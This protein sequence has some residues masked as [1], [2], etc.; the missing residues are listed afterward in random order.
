MPCGWRTYCGP[1]GRASRHRREPRDHAPQSTT[2]SQ[3]RMNANTATLKCASSQPPC[4]IS[5]EQLPTATATLLLPR[6]R[7]KTS[8]RLAHFHPVITPLA[9]GRLTN[10]S[11]HILRIDDEKQWRQCYDG[12]DLQRRR[13]KTKTKMF[14]RCTRQKQ[15]AFDGP[16]RRTSDSASKVASVPSDSPAPRTSD[17][18]PPG[19][20][21]VRR[22]R[23]RAIASEATSPSS[24]ALWS[25]PGGA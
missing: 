5:P 25:A 22:R 13:F 4:F 17:G 21:T 6:R 18:R 24:I 15:R 2:S 16:Q 1:V 12:G 7:G 10:V 14:S 19:D 8:I 9:F 23:H 3:L 20:R 11:R